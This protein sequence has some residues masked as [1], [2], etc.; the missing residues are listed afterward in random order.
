MASTI[1]SH[2]QSRHGKLW[3][4]IVVAEKLKNWEKVKILLASVSERD[5]ASN[6][7][8]APFSLEGFLERLVRWIVVD[9]QV[10]A[11]IILS[12]FNI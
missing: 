8:K 1:W 9:N 7:A 6:G 12:F 10:S 11:S 2:L 3:Q 4:N 5:A